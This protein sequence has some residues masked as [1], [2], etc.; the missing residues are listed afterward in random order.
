MADRSWASV[1]TPYVRP[2]MPGQPDAWAEESGEHGHSGTHTLRE[3]REAPV[4]PEVAL[5][6]GIAADQAAVVR[7]RTV[8]LDDHPVE[9]ADSYYPVEIARG[10]PLAEHR[11]IRG[12]A[13][14]LLTELGFQPRRAEEDVSARPATEDERRLLHLDERSWVMVL[15]RRL[16]ADEGRPIEVSVITMAVPG[17]HLRYDLDL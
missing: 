12:G 3:V 1:S 13:V 4:P 11:K 17:R 2:R 8:L 15:V 7:R 16:L 9:L 14:T 10:T 5:A 6:L